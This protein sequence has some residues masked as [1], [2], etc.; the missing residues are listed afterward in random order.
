MWQPVLEG[1]LADRAVVRIREITQGLPKELSP[2]DEALFWAYAAPRS[3]PFEAAKLALIDRLEEGTAGLQL[4]GGL[5]GAGWVLAHV[6][7]DEPVLRD[8]DETLIAALGRDRWQADLDLSLGL[9]GMAVYFLERMPTSRARAGIQAVVGHLERE[10]RITDHGITWARP[11][12]RRSVASLERSPGDLYDT[13]AAH[14]VAGIVSVLGRITALGD[15][16]PSA[17]MLCDGG[18][19]WLA[20]QRRDETTTTRFP[21]FVS[22]AGGSDQARNAWCYGDPGLVIAA[23]AAAARTTHAGA[24]WHELAIEAASRSLDSDPGT[25][26][27]CHGAFGLAH[28]FNRCYQASRDSVLRIAACTWFGRGLAMTSPEDGDFL[29][30]AV[31]VG[32][33]LLAGLGHDEPGWDRRLACDVPP[34]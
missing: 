21:S 20:A 5:A 17:A 26:G 33:A 1:E 14:G 4:H 23:W 3:E 11:A 19:Q 6:A 25:M 29:D 7:G 16:A 27:L 13:G 2:E 18:L 32:L 12:A 30:G 24:T 28:L 10:A 34:T 9:A 8:I 15:V 22:G 31:G